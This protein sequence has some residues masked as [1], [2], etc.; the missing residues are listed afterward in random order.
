MD[1]GDRTMAASD[2]RAFLKQ[3]MTLAGAGVAG[4]V[5]IS[6]TDV[7]AQIIAPDDA[8]LDTQRVVLQDPA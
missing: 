7:Q 5:V 4:Y 6:D 2:R 8:R 1:K 3:C